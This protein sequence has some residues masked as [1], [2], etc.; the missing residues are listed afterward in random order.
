MR[1]L[2]PPLWPQ[3]IEIS[4]SRGRVVKASD[5]KSDSLWELDSQRSVIY[6][7]FTYHAAKMAWLLTAADWLTVKWQFR[8]SSRQEKDDRAVSEGAESQ[9]DYV[10]LSHVIVH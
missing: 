5:S 3:T 6:S 8:Y 4:S 1:G 2:F 10:A 7:Q 9:G